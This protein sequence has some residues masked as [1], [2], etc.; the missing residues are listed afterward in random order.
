MQRNPIIFSASCCIVAITVIL[1]SPHLGLVRP[2]SYSCKR[3]VLWFSSVSKIVDLHNL[4]PLHHLSQSMLRP[5]FCLEF[6]VAS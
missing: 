2:W 6:G 1:F 4:L 5:C 3:T